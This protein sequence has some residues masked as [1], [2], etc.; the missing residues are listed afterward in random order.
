MSVVHKVAEELKTVGL[1]TLYF[2]FCFGIVFLLKRLFLAEYQIEFRGL[3][4]ALMGALLAGKVVVVLEKAPVGKWIGDRA[5]VVEMVARTLLYTVG[6]MIAV[7]AE[8]AFAARHEYGGFLSALPRVFS[9]RE[10]NH[11][12]ATVICVSLS[13]LAFNTGSAVWR[14]L[15]KETLVKLFF[16]TKTSEVGDGPKT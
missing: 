10:I 1:V 5:V 7:L 13:F 11:V 9:H 4:V 6:A 2:A 12:W 14:H 8:H 3:S 16:E 15:G